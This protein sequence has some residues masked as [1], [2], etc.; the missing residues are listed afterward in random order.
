MPNT[1]TNP[2]STLTAAM[3]ICL[4][5]LV[6]LMPSMAAAQSTALSDKQGPVLIGILTRAFGNVPMADG[7]TL[8]L[9][10]LGYDEFADFVIGTR[11]TSGDNAALPAVGKELLMSGADILIGIGTAATQA[12]SQATDEKP[13]LFL[14][15]SDPIG[16]SLVES[17]A[18]PGG[19]VTGIVNDETSLDIRRFELFMSLAP[20]AKQILY[21]LDK[22]SE[23]PSRLPRLQELAKA[24]KV[25]LID[26]HLESMDAAEQ[27]FNTID[28]EPI[29]GIYMTSAI[30]NNIIGFALDSAAKHGIPAV[31][32][33][34]EYAADLGGLASYGSS[35]FESGRQLARLVQKIINGQKPANIPV[36]VDRFFELVVNLKAA[37]DMGVQI[38]P[39]I[40]FKADKVIR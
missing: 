25:E 33:A 19:N 24:N 5:T 35:Y 23:D 2:T 37:N 28:H 11:F 7:L 32:P 4:S 15:V 14:S 6:S 10:E 21:P 29:D 36:E 39:E 27:Y 1:K 13:I 34:S 40:L 16:A 38:S 9:T 26:R 20:H 31:F 22:N 18:R 8:G 3:V 12:L 17:F 30:E